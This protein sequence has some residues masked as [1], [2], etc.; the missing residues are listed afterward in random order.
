MIPVITISFVILSW[1]MLTY[2]PLMCIAGLVTSFVTENATSVM[3]NPY[4]GIIKVSQ[5]KSIYI[6]NFRFILFGLALFFY[7]KWYHYGI[8]PFIPL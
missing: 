7:S 4:F 6:W 2:I 8:N 1:L 3:H 5:N